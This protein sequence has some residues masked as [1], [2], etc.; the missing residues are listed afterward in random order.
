MS[1]RWYLTTFKNDWRGWF[2]MA[3]Q[4]DLCLSLP[5]IAQKLKLAVEQLQTG[6]FQNPQKR[7]SNSKD[8]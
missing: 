4:R 1:D 5:G 7:Y 6:G 8:K 3:E 2:K